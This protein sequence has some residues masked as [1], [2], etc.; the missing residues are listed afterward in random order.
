[1][2]ERAFILSLLLMTVVAH[3]GLLLCRGWLIGELR[4]E[5]SK[6]K[7]AWEDFKQDQEQWRKDFENEHKA[8]WQRSTT[9]KTA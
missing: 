9:R 6:M 5:Q 3:I 7:T 2:N 8:P 1:M 4:R